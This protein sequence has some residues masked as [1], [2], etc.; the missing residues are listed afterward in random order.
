MYDCG[1]YLSMKRGACVP[2]RG[3]SGPGCGG[4]WARHRTLCVFDGLTHGASAHLSAPMR[5]N[6]WHLKRLIPL[7]AQPHAAGSTWLP[8]VAARATFVPKF[9]PAGSPFFT[10][11]LGGTASNPNTPPLHMH[12]WIG[13]AVLYVR[14]SGFVHVCPEREERSPREVGKGVELVGQS[15]ANLRS[16]LLSAWVAYPR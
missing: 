15:L 14:C 7:H 1:P 4:K 2:R 10:P 13:T 12:R 16:V 8:C 11:G 6:P 5:V 3:S 9:A